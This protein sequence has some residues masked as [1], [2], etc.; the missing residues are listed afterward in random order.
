MQTE[1][2]ATLEQSE[3][4]FHTKDKGILLIA[5][6]Q[7]SADFSGMTSSILKKK[8]CLS[9]RQIQHTNIFIFSSCRLALKHSG[10]FLINQNCC[11]FYIEKLFSALRSVI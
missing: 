5:S 9:F 11:L 10:T 6:C 1:D 2:K 7:S 3:I 4:T 8:A